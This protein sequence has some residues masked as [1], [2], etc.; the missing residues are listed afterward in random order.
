MNIR[1]RVILSEAEQ[2]QLQ[3]LLSA[4][5]SC[6][7]EVKGTQILLA[8]AEGQTEQH[9]AKAVRTSLAKIYRLK[10]QNAGVRSDIR[11]KRWC[12]V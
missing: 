1:Y 8:A 5:R 3:A 11:T 7:R 9:I 6:V 4:G 2:A 12:Q 10:G